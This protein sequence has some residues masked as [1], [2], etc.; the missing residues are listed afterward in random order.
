M[1]RTSEVIKILRYPLALAVVGLCL[2]G[3]AFAQEEKN[4]DKDATKA[5]PAS[6]T[7]GQREESRKASLTA[8]VKSIDP[9]TRQV[10]LQGA[11]GKETTLTVGKE[12]RAF[13]ELKVGDTVTADYHVSLAGEVRPPTAEEKANPLSE[14]EVEGKSEPGADP[15]AVGARQMKAVTTVQSID[16]AKKTVTI[17]GPKGN[18]REIAV[19]D[20]ATL[21]K[22]KQGDSV[23]ITFTEAMAVSLEKKE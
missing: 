21:Q 20:P 7:P 17:K 4:K 1:K 2:S 12:V 3:Q 18:T 14:T 11:E 22:L 15:T 9:A 10:T 8:T 13:D 16:Q 19:K 5:K 6:G 23:V